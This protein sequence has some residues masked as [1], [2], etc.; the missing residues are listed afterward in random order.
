MIS[1][2]F[3]SAVNDFEW[4]DDIN[5]KGQQDFVNTAVFRKLKLVTKLN[6]AIKSLRPKE[7]TWRHISWLTNWPL[8]DFNEI[9]RKVIFKLI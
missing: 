6:E 5:Q 3:S 7:N 1:S 8:G 9:W 2:T 4:T